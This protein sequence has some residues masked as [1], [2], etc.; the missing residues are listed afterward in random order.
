MA[1]L[2]K[3]EQNPQ[4]QLLEEIKGSRCVML[5]SPDHDQHM[6]PM[7]PQVDEEAGIIYFYSD[8]T[9]E[10]GQTV[11]KSPGMVHM[12][13]IDKDY[14]ACVRGELAP[15]HDKSTVEKFWGPVVDAWYPGGTEDPKLM[16]LK[17][18]P[19]DAALWASDKSALGVFFEV[20]KANIKDEQPDLGKSKHV[21]L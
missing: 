17:F 10:L 14:Q 3:F 11:L 20:A 8:K 18:V 6:Q 13:H 15:H 4:R 2:K 12:C 21:Q 7:A 5:G 1:N 9:S 19:H 16:M